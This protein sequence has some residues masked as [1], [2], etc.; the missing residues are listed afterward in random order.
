MTSSIQTASQAGF[1]AKDV[2]FSAI[3]SCSFM[4]VVW[5]ES[6]LYTGQG[7]EPLVHALLTRSSKTFNKSNGACMTQAGRVRQPRLGSGGAGS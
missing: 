2:A 6:L 4:A 5:A 1:P 7:P 3:L